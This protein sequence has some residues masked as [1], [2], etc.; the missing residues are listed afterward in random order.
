[1]SGRHGGSSAR[2]AQAPAAE[3]DLNPGDQAVPG[4]PGTGENLCPKCAGSGRLGRN[5][6]PN[7]GGT[8]KVIEGI[9]GA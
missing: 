3:S 7:C 6:C 4:T 5:P 1:M 9:G 2:R 8:G